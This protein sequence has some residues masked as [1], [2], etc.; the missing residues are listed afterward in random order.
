VLSVIFN[1]LS[2]LISDTSLKAQETT[3][4][5]KNKFSYT[6]I[7]LAINIMMKNQERQMDDVDEEEEKYTLAL[8]ILN[9]LKHVSKE[10]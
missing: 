4:I 5:F 9:F 3:N 8:S 1:I 7:T 2:N 10:N 6:A